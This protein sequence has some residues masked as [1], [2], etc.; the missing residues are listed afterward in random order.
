MGV[1]HRTS[2]WL[3]GGR[4][5]KRMRATPRH[6]GQVI[7][8][9]DDDNDDD[10]EVTFAGTRQAPLVDNIAAP[11]V[12]HNAVVGEEEEEGMTR[13]RFLAILGSPTTEEDEEEVQEVEGMARERAAVA[14][15]DVAAGP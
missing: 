6:L 4:L 14:D 12:V 11:A 5:S 2:G 8:I 13:E 7:I 9:D 10:E 15:A 3:Q 1:D